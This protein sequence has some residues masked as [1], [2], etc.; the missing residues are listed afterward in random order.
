MGERQP[1]R[2]V[3]RCLLR[4][5]AIEGHQR[6]R[7]AGHADEV[8]APA[9]LVHQHDLD[10]VA[11]SV[12]NFV[13]AMNGHGVDAGGLSVERGTA[14]FYIVGDW[15]QAKGDAKTTTTEARHARAEPIRSIT[16][17]ITLPS[18]LRA[19]FLHMLSTMAQARGR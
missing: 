17:L 15:R 19:Q 4:R 12:D 10:R 18:T 5:R 8:G 9:V 6:C 2:K 13:E 3:L 7:S 11:S 16:P 14:K 1:V